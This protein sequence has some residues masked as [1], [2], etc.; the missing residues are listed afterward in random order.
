MIRLLSKRRLRAFRKFLAV[1]R[2]WMWTN[3][4]LVT[5]CSPLDETQGLKQADKAYDQFYAQ[6][7]DLQTKSKNVEIMLALRAASWCK[8]AG[9]GKKRKAKA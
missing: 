9:N 8:A 2:H 6:N 4:L 3:R 1:F 5:H 7:P